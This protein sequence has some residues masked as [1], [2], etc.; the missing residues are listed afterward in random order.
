MNRREALKIVEF[1]IKYK[2]FEKPEDLDEGWDNNDV[3][4][5]NDDDDDDNDDGDGDGDEA[6]DLLKSLSLYDLIRLRPEEA[7][8]LLTYKDYLELPYSN[9]LCGLPFGPSEACH[10]HLCEKLSRG[11]FRRWSLELFWEL[12][13]YQ[14]PIL[15]CEM[16]IKDLMNEDLCHICLAA[17][18]QGS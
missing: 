1:F 12:T 18:N 15:C 2:L 6:K 17:T 9:I 8:K 5:D 4:D 11:F 16:I 14:L 7:A 3:D 10:R 13:K